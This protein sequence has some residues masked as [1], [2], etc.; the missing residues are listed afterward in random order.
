MLVCS[1][2]AELSDQGNSRN[3]LQRRAQWERPGMKEVRDGMSKS[4]SA[5]ENSLSKNLD[6]MEMKDIIKEIIKDPDFDL[7]YDYAP[8]DDNIYGKVQGE[9]E[10][11]KLPQIEEQPE[12]SEEEQEVQK[13][14]PIF[15]FVKKP[16]IKEVPLVSVNL[17]KIMGIKK[18]LMSG[19]NLLN[20][21]KD[22]IITAKKSLKK[23][24][25]LQKKKYNAAEIR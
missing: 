9:E 13:I 24:Q 2:R 16:G 17:L 14:E 21:M 8:I 3:L 10:E 1:V 12:S 7:G 18:D 6:F 15:G 19:D 22:K 11:K 20:K 5:I 25:K 23:N 4:R